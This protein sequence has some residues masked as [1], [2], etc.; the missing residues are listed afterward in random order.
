MKNFF[1]FSILI[2]SFLPLLVSADEI[3]LKERDEKAILSSLNQK[4]S[5]K[6]TEMVVLNSPDVKKEAIFVILQQEIKFEV[7]NSTIKEIGKMGINAVLKLT[8]LILI[9]EV[10][11]VT[12]IK[13][14]EKLT[15]D[16]AREYATDWLLQKEVKVGNGNLDYYYQVQEKKWEKGKFPYIITYK[17]SSMD[18]G[19]IAISIYSSETVRP[20]LPSGAFQWEGGI[21]EIPPFILQI[22]GRVRETNLGA[23]QWIKGPE[24]IFIFNEPVPEFEFKEPT[25]VDE[26]KS[27]FNRTIKAAEKVLGIGKEKVYK[28]ISVV[29][30]A[31]E[32]LASFISEMKSLGGGANVSSPLVYEEKTKDHSELNESLLDLAKKIKEAMPKKEGDFSFFQDQIDD[33][34]EQ[35]DIISQRISSIQ[36]KNEP[37]S[38]EPGSFSR[39]GEGGEAE[40]DKEEVVV[41][42]AKQKIEKKDEQ[43]LVKTKK[44]SGGGGGAPPIVYCSVENQENPLMAV[45]FNEIAWMGTN[46]SANDEWIELKNL[47]GGQINLSGWQ[48]LDKEN[49]IKI[50]FSNEESINDLFLLER[51]DDNTIPGI[52]ADKIYSGALNDSSEQLYLFDNNCRIQDK[53]EGEYWPAG[54]KENKKSMERS[55]DFAWH[56]F[57]GEGYSTPGLENS[58]SPVLPVVSE[59]D[60]ETTPIPEEPEN[61]PEEEVKKIMINEIAWMGTKASANDEWIELYNP[62]E[63]SV[64][65]LGWQLLFRPTEGEER[66]T[67]FESVLNQQTPSIDPLGYFLLERTDDNVIFDEPADY[68][69]KG[70]LNDSG[71]SFELKDNYGRIVDSAYFPE[72]WPAGEKEGGKASMERIGEE[73]KTNNLVVKNGRDH[74]SNDIFGTPKAKNSRARS[75]INVYSL[76]FDDFDNITFYSESSPYIINSSITIPEL[77]TLEIEP[78]TTLKFKDT[79][80]KILVEGTLKAE[81]TEEKQI[82]FTSLRENPFAGSWGRIHFKPNSTGSNLSYIILEYGGGDPAGTPCSDNMAGI[83]SEAPISIANSIIR[84]N[85]KNGIYLKNTSSIIENVKI[86]GNQPCIAG[87]N[88]KYGGHGIRAEKGSLEVKNCLFEGNTIGL[89]LDEIEN[90]LAKE[91]I[92]NDN[93]KAITMFRSSANFVSNIAEN[94][95]VEGIWISDSLPESSFWTNNLPFIISGKLRISEG[96]KLEIEK[97]AVLK[98]KDSY[99]KISVGGTLKVSG[100]EGQEVLFSPLKE[101]PSPGSWDKI[102]FDPTSIDSE[103]NYAIFEY[104]GGGYGTPCNPTMSTLLIKETSVL[105]SNVTVK[106]SQYRGIYLIDSNSVLNNVNIENTVKC[107]DIYGGYDITVEGG[108]PVINSEEHQDLP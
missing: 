84:N 78:G 10:S 51:T 104:A 66:I 58:I 81:G 44:S 28:T 94:N 90:V 2:C 25:F 59:S 27:S 83:L 15:V 46:N 39:K 32:S 92:F 80:A 99:S 31:W 34:S 74:D 91:N 45:I 37:G 30:N 98:F 3:E 14:I 86:I 62:N 36:S 76:P 57:S 96:S 75:G 7:L 4:I 107:M 52:A 22:T 1:I 48:I 69:F 20:P 79:H 93:E 43:P 103:I 87:E 68:I 77:K 33:L 82:L 67:V 11:V 106:N 97:G 54:D 56:T 89:K 50:V 85:E 95:G 8:E 100:E 9:K 21:D 13:E 26:I 47:S 12:A 64:D 23:Y 73:W 38:Y 40:K 101:D 29:K 24:F 108:N 5:D 61:N 105:I 53:I 35:L 70:A 88:A 16:Q 49:Q 18:E 41:E 42:I 63:E 6:I 102:E 65:I 60:E 71:G 19:D 17:Q 72:G 55:P